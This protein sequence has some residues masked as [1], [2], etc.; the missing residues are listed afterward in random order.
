MKRSNRAY[1]YRVYPTHEQETYLNK[2]LG[3]CRLYWNTNLA[4]KNDNHSNRLLTYKQLFSKYKP[5]A[6]EWIKDISVSALNNE[7][8]H[9]SQAFSNFANSLKKQRKGKFVNPPKF[10]TGLGAP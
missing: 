5:E 8:L 10:K 2:T 9:I 6:L 7:Y 1:E 3:L 4:Q